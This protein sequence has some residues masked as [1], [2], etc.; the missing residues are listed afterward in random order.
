MDIKRIVVDVE[1]VDH[2]QIKGAAARLG[3]T[4]KEYVLTAIAYFERHKIRNAK[5]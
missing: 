3:M 5:K 1:L 2:R 4:V